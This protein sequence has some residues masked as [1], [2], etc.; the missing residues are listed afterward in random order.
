MFI[1][2]FH[3]GIVHLQASP[4]P[5]LKPGV[6]APRCISFTGGRYAAALA[7]TMTLPLMFTASFEAGLK[8]GQE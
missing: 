3:S 8:A 6:G 7:R 1:L 4:H 2:Q 5:R